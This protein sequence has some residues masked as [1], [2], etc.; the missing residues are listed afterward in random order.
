[1]RVDDEG[2]GFAFTSK[3]INA[4][5]GNNS[6][7]RPNRFCD[8]ALEKNA[9]PVALPPGFAR[10]ATKSNFTGSAPPEKTIGIV[11]VAALAACAA[12]IADATITLTFRFASSVAIADSR[13]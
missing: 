5:L 10:L 3:P 1:M 7:R 4:A 6:W 9:I 2:L 13:S 12:L 8:T 11:E